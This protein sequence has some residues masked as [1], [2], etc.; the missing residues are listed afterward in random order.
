MHI[1]V[2][3]V[4]LSVAFSAGTVTLCPAG[5]VEDRADGTTVHVTLYSVPDPTRT[6]TTS[7]ADT[8]VM[9]EFLRRIPDLIAER[10]RSRYEA[11][12][13]TYGDHDWSNVDVR[14]HRFS[15][16]KVEG[17]EADLLAIA[18]G[19]RRTCST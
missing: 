12:P 3:M 16:I 7:R 10:Y 15:G 9:K 14:L 2:A 4:L 19:W 18:G 11:D 17:V 5:W 6:D 1:R 13:A 8:A